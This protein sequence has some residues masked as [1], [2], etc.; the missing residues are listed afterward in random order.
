MKVLLISCPQW[1]NLTPPYNLSLLSSILKNGGHET[2]I[3][4]LNIECYHHLMS[5]DKNDYWQGNNYFHWLAPQF[6]NNLLPKLN[7]LLDRAVDK[8]IKYDPEFVGVSIYETNFECVKVL[9]EK[10]KAVNK[11]IKIMAGGP[12]CFNMDD[13][14]RNMV[15]IDLLFT[16]EADNIVNKAIE[17]YNAPKTYMSQRGIVLNDLPFADYDSYD[18]NNYI[19]VNGISMEASRG[20]VAKCSFCMET[21]FWSF[22]SKTAERL[23]QEIKYYKE[24]YNISYVRFNDSLI[25]GNIKEFKKF[26]YGLA[27]EKLGVRWGSYIRI[28]KRMDNEFFKK[29]KESNNSFLSFG[30]ESGSQKVLYD[31]K[32]GIEIK[33]IEQNLKDSKQHGLKSQINWIIGFPTE[34]CHDYLL[35]LAFVYNNRKNIFQLCP[36]MTCGIGANSDLRLNP[37]RYDLI[38]EWPWKS[39][40]TK[41]FKNTI[42][43]RFIRLKFFH[44]FLDMLNIDN[45]QYHSKIKQEYDYKGTIQD[46]II[47]YDSCVDFSYLDDGTFESSLICEYMSFFWCVYK[48][49]NEF[50]MN[51]RF[52][53]DEDRKE[54]GDTI[55]RPYNANIDFQIN[56]DSNWSLNISHSLSEQVIFDNKIHLKGNINNATI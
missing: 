9:I 44:I 24:K 3:I 26:V 19:E 4:D 33:E 38:Q 40:T 52:N 51:V 6:K 12:Q 16:G 25:N 55:V 41:D 34:T 48:I 46:I 56:N 8:I 45:G 17:E 37:K 49:S 2:N 50:K 43:H 27:E 7:D 23:L 13:V 14:T 36:G 32:K 21:C 20:C 42:I 18:L 15:G 11:N 35:S 29:I 30:V 47:D 5:I 31:M 1:S 39:F 54:F 22:R 53:Q 28:D 10:I